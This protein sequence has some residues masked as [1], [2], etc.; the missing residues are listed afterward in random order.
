M[1]PERGNPGNHVLVQRKHL[2]T[3][4]CHFGVHGSELPAVVIK[5]GLH[6]DQR[7]VN[8]V[9][10][11]CH[12]CVHGSELLVHGCEF[13]SH[14]PPHR[15]ELRVRVRAEVCDGRLEAVYPLFQHGDP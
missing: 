5:L 12:L 4:G 3:H 14:F 6:S 13:C 15:R 8:G 2:R 9:E 7:L 1:F 11:R 10:A